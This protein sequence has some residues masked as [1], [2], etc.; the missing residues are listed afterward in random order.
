MFVKPLIQDQMGKPKL[1]SWE[2]YKN[3]PALFSEAHK[4]RLGF[5]QMNE[6]YGCAKCD[7]MRDAPMFDP[8]FDG[9]HDGL[10]YCALGA[11][12]V[13]LDTKCDAFTFAT[14]QRSAPMTP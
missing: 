7:Y 10:M 1:F 12:R 13:Y 8:N 5:R 6:T 3:L 14:K 9:T 2:Q 11:Y 4:I